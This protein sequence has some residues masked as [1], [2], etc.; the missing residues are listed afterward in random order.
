MPRGSTCLS[1]VDGLCIRRDTVNVTKPSLYS[2]VIFAEERTDATLI[3]VHTP[4]S[5]AL[6]EHYPEKHVACVGRAVNL[7]A[8]MAPHE[9]MVDPLIPL[10]LLETVRS[11]DRPEGE[12]EAEYVPELLNK[13]LGMT[14]TV[15]AQI[16]RYG[17]AVQRGQ[18]IGADEVTALS[19]LIS[20]RPDATHVFSVAGEAAARAAVYRRVSPECGAASSVCCARFLRRSLSATARARQIEARYFHVPLDTA[21]HDAGMRELTT[22]LALH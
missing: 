1:D 5:K 13:R 10:T 9:S 3:K 7:G 16:R 15:L 11:I 6:G 19:R 4:P 22:L 8:I 20:R 12:A 17:D 14:D 2:C 21:Y 18:R